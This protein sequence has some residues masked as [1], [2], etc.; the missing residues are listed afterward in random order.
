M[1]P[2]GARPMPSCSVAE[3]ALR[4]RTGQSGA[5]SGCASLPEDLAE[6]GRPAI[7]LNSLSLLALVLRQRAVQHADAGRR[8]SGAHLLWRLDRRGRGKRR[9]D[10]PAS[11]CRLREVQAVL[12][13]IR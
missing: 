4:I 12:D 3:R 1:L 2:D 9:H 8:P 10:Q 13:L 7:T 5:C 6:L 11:V